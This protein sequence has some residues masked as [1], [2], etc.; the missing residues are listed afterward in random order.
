MLD[1]LYTAT[2]ISSYRS[3]FGFQ[4]LYVLILCVRAVKVLARLCVCTDLSKPSLLAY[5]ISTKSHVL[6]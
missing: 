5:A 1:P 4:L 2:L 3:L 6:P